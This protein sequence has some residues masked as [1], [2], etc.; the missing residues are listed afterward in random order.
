MVSVGANRYVAPTKGATKARRENTALNPEPFLN[1][2]C[3]L[4][5]KPLAASF[6]GS[7]PFPECFP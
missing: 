4:A 5:R 2:D 7:N 6:S 3:A 1:R